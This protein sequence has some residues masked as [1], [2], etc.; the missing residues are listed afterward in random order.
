MTSISFD[1]VIALANRVVELETRQAFQ[2][3]AV[4]ALSDVVAQQ[5]RM[6]ERLELQVAAL[7]KRQD[8]LLGQLGGGGA[9]EE[10]PPPHY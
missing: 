1:D 10:P 4:Q 6:L 3:D 7:I 5:Q 8:E 9:E 2:D